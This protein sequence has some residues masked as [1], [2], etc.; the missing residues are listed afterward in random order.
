MEQVSTN[1]QE[2]NK[3]KFLILFLV[4]IALIFGFF[5]LNKQI[6]NFRA[7]LANILNPYKS[8]L[9]FSINDKKLDFQTEDNKLNIKWEGFNITLCVA[10]SSPEINEWSGEKNI[11]GEENI[12]INTT[13]KFILTCAGP[14]G[15][16]SKEINVEL[17]SKKAEVTPLF[18]KIEFKKLEEEREIKA[19]KKIKTSLSQRETVKTTISKRSFETKQSLPQPILEFKINNAE[20]DIEIKPEDKIN[21]MWEAKNVDKCLAFSQ[22]INKEWSDYVK[23]SGSKTIEKLDKSTTFGIFCTYNKGY[24]TKSINVKLLIKQIN[25]DFKANDKSEDI[26]MPYRSD[27]TLSWNAENAERCEALSNPEVVNWKGDI[28]L[29]GKRSIFNLDKDT[30]FGIK[31]SNRYQTV[32]KYIK[33]K[34]IYVGGGGGGGVFISQQAGS[35][36]TGGGSDT[37]SGSSN[38][39]NTTQPSVDLKINNQNGP[40]SANKGDTINLSWNSTNAKTCT[41][42]AS[43]YYAEWSGFKNTQGNVNITLTKAG[44]TTFSIS[45]VSEDGKDATDQV[46]V[47]VKEI[48]NKFVDIKVNSQDN[49]TINKGSN[50]NVKWDSNGV[51]S[52]TVSS[53]PNIEGW[54][55][56]KPTSGETT[57]GPI[58]QRTTLSISCLD[59][60]GNDY[61]DQA[62]IDVN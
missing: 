15:L 44:T 62:I 24:I 20:K 26:S 14:G 25:L 50:V 38:N 19:E 32:E 4:L 21:I 52:C 35:G 60:E 22:P 29:S 55:G 23:S 41:V 31:C 10:S 39:Q 12:T 51:N 42:S 46:I 1:N 13:T 36:T 61:T 37:G 28:Q 47:Y 40:I 34:I 3:N 7:Y 45:C 56:V 6:K 57:L 58:N 16:V 9:E 30:I 17:I 59:Q 54:S 11:N 5:I 48:I 2:K 49:I 27:V 43:P 33:A 18:K 53:S 8:D